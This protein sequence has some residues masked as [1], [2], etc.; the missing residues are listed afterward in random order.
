MYPSRFGF[1]E[2]VKDENNYHQLRVVE[3][4]AFGGKV[5]ET[6][7]IILYRCCLTFSSGREPRASV[8]RKTGFTLSHVHRMC[9]Y[10]NIYYDCKRQIKFRLTGIWRCKSPVRGDHLV[11]SKQS[12][13]PRAV[14]FRGKRYYM[15][16]KYNI[17]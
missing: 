14:D 15:R 10:D 4:A 7:Y 16:I 13:R 8:T 6:Y 9:I 1:I 11:L 3:S 17:L 12:Y 5:S 2:C